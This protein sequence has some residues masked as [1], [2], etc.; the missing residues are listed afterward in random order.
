MD[1]IIVVVSIA[2]I[3]ASLATIACLALIT[4]AL[5]K[6]FAI[7]QNEIE[8]KREA[9][10][11][12]AKNDHSSLEYSNGLLDFVKTVVAQTTVLKFRSFIDNR[13]V[14]KITLTQLKKFVQEIVPL[15]HDS[16]V[17]GNMDLNGVMFTE[18]FLNIYIIE[19][20]MIMAKELLD[21]AINEEDMI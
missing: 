18:R 21:K 8:V 12:A 16:L 14:S 5:R 15:I 6:Y 20:S 1:S 9:N 11:I 17:I 4:I 2:V 7:K 3:C 13:D 19:T 10:K